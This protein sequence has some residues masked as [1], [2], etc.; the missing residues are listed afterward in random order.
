MPGGFHAWWV[1]SP[2]KGK[3]VVI[4][5]KPTYLKSMHE[6][7]DDKSKFHMITDPIETVCRTTEDKINRFLLSANV[8]QIVR[9]FLNGFIEELPL[10]LHFPKGFQYLELQVSICFI[11]FVGAVI[12]SIMKP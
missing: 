9:H 11:T 8:L 7:I 12:I 2:D 1:A 10:L 5:S 6:I 4:V 3:G